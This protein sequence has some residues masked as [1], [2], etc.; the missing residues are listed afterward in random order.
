MA[1]AMEVGV[2]GSLHPALPLPTVAPWK[3]I[4]QILAMIH[5]VTISLRSFLSSVA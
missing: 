3:N 2:S 1:M 5:L 4:P